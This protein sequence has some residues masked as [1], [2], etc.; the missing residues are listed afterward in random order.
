MTLLPQSVED[1]RE[2]TLT[3]GPRMAAEAFLLKLAEVGP[4][5]QRA[6]LCGLPDTRTLT[7]RFEEAWPLREAAL[8]GVPFLTKDLYFRQDEPTFAGSTFLPQEIGAARAT[9]SLP[10][11]FEADAGAIEC[12]RTQLNEFAFGLSGE[13]PHYGDCPHPTRPDLLAGGSSSGSAFAVARGATWLLTVDQDSSLPADYVSALL[14][15]AT[16]RVGVIGAEII[17]D[18]SGDVRYPTTQ[19]DGHLTTEE[20]FQTGSLWS[21][22]A[23]TA[24]GGFDES[25]GID[26]VDAAACLR[27]RERG[28]IVALAAGVRLEHRVG[29]ARQVT[30]LGRTVLATGHSP[31]RRT[32]MVRN[33]LRLAPAEFRQSPKH[34]FRTLRRVGVNAVLGATVEENRWAKT[35]GTIKGL[36]PSR[37]R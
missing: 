22:A 30:L 14:A 28:F 10:A 17:S 18:A 25:L 29:A 2:F 35:K 11:A 16:D 6:A 24:I 37:S 20:V 3:R 13:N 32:T 9:S 4:A 7:R 21:V 31:E 33:R 5:E 8:G 23:L 36:W 19:S 26:A 15:A 1:W 27:L 12:G 34:A